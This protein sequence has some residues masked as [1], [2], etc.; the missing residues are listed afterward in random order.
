MNS[1]AVKFILKK[2]II[3]DSQKGDHQDDKASFSDPVVGSAV[4]VGAVD[5]ECFRAV[6]FTESKRCAHIRWKTW[7]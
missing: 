4:T 6:E 7:A 5:H 1:F 3:T 2:E